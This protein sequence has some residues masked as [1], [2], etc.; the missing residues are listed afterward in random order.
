LEF[1]KGRPGDEEE[2]G[3]EGREALRITDGPVQPK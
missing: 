2:G 1:H 3:D